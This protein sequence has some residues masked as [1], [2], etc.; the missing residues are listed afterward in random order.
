MYND[1]R[2]NDTT[3]GLR[4]LQL[5]QSETGALND[6]F[7]SKATGALLPETPNW[8]TIGALIIRIGFRGPLYYTYNKEPPKWYR[9]FLRFKPKATTQKPEHGVTNAALEVTSVRT[10]V[11]TY[12]TVPYIAY[13]PYIQ[14]TLFHC[15]AL[16]GLHTGK[17]TKQ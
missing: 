8:A 4:T 14:H 9:Q 2:S 7:T 3:L 12:Q 17:L 15:A 1:Y 5:R 16:H 6:A 13:M 11:S 10:H